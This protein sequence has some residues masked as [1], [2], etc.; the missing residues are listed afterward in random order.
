M[1][2]AEQLSYEVT[3]S[4]SILVRYACNESL[5]TPGADAVNMSEDRTWSARSSGA[6]RLGRAQAW[7]E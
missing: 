1:D 5:R 2:W 6:H 7:I 3:F 4:E